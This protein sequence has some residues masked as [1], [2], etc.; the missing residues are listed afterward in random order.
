[1]KKIFFFDIDGTLA[2]HGQIPSSNLEVLKKLQE[3]GHLTFIC[4]GRAPFYADKLFG[5]LV[6]GI[7][8]CNGRYITYRGNVVHCKKFT[9]EEL[10]FYQNK[11]DEMNVGALFV[12]DEKSYTY[13]L[14]LQ[15]IEEVNQEYGNERIDEYNEQQ[16][17]YTLDLFYN[18]LRQRN[19]LIE[20]FK[21][22]L[23]INDHGGHGSCDCSTIGFDKGN[24]IAF[25]LDYFNIA[26]EDSYAFGDGYNDQAMFREVSHAIAMGNAVDELKKSN[27][28]NRYN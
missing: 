10:E 19:R 23:I 22:Q 1:M 14:N 5:H 2:I 8:C 20:T 24:G 27:I 11:I 9:L 28:H 15:Q 25:L 12:S 21:K 26:K 4:T 13:H 3:K 17:Y 18:N 7:V 6:D 16:D